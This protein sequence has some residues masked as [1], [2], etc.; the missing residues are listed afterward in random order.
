MVC[1]PILRQPHLTAMVF[2]SQKFNSH[3]ILC[4]ISPS[5]IRHPHY[6]PTFSPI[7]MQSQGG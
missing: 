4:L 5:F 6:P 1:P 3:Y 2:H 7:P